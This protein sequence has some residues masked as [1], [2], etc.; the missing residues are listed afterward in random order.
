MS[1][2]LEKELRVVNSWEMRH[3]GAIA[4]EAEGARV[5]RKSAAQSCSLPCYGLDSF[6][7]LVVELGYR[8]WSVDAKLDA[9]KV[10]LILPREI[11]ALHSSFNFGINVYNE[12]CEEEASLDSGRGA[13]YLKDFLLLLEGV[14][15]VQDPLVDH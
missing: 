7:W 13:A 12:K 1:L 2:K 9:R 8:I 10:G 14:Q 6:K 3:T 11:L 15:I 4:T 5:R